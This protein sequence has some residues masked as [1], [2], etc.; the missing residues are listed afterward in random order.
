MTSTQIGI[1]T[2]TIAHDEDKFRFVPTLPGV[3][4]VH[5]IADGIYHDDADAAMDEAYGQCTHMKLTVNDTEVVIEGIWVMKSW[6]A[7]GS[8]RTSTTMVRMR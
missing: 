7:V 4:D 8:G 5:D 1:G 6:S 3:G 2:I